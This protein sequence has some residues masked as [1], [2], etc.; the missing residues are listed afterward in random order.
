V[1]VVVSEETGAVSLVERGRIVRNLDETRLA[2][3]LLDLLEHDELPNARLPERATALRKTIPQA[4][5]RGRARVA[6]SAARN[7]TTTTSVATPAPATPAT[8]PAAA[9]ASSPSSTGGRAE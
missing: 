6:R 1:V 7:Q 3:A 9:A 8:P 5:R 2:S 4:A